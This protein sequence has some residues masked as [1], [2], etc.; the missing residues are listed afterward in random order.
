MT[1]TLLIKILALALALVVVAILKVLIAILTLIVFILTLVV[2]PRVCLRGIIVFTPEVQMTVSPNMSSM[3]RTF[4]LGTRVFLCWFGL[5]GRLLGLLTLFLRILNFLLFALVGFGN[6]L[7]P[8]TIGAVAVVCRS[9]T[10][11]T[12]RR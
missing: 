4:F 9:V 8:P 12:T 3:D 11:L 1:L 5:F 2:V 7:L 10:R 6:L